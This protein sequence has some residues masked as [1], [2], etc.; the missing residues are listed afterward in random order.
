MTAAA[1]AIAV[2]HK[3]FFLLNNVAVLVTSSS[4][5]RQLSFANCSGA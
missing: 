2:P 5:T 4:S 1:I 3:N